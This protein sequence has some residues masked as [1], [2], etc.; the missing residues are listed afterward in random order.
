MYQQ[1]STCSLSNIN[2]NNGIKIK[3]IFIP[4]VRTTNYS[5]KQLKAKGLGSA[6]HYIYP[7]TLK[8]YHPCMFS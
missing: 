1:N 5:R 7:L 6:M 4:S 3:N 2:I 8:I